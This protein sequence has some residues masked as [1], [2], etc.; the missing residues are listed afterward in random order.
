MYDSLQSHIAYHNKAG[1]CKITDN[2]ILVSVDHVKW[3][4][5]LNSYQTL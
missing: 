1:S 2:G 3:A 5:Q 4:V